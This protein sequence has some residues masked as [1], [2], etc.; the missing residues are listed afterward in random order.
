MPCNGVAVAKSQVP[1]S[2]AAY[3]KL[4]DRETVRQAMQQ[5]LS[6]QFSDIRPAPYGDG[7]IVGERFLVQTTGGEVKVTALAARRRKSDRARAA[8]LAEEVTNL[9]TGLAGLSLQQSVARQ[10]I[11]AGYQV[12]RLQQAPNGALVLEVEL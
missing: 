10:V 6:R 9:L 2:L 12:E 8:A 3:L 4:T 5:F 1:V 11:A 7:L